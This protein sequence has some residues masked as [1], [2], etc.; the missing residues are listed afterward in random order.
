MML[1]HGAR[2][3]GLVTLGLFAAFAWRA[4]A[5]DERTLQN[6]HGSV[7]YVTGDGVPAHDLAPSAS[8]V[9]ADDDVART[10]AASMASIVLG[11]SSQ[12]LMASNSVLKLDMFSQA[13]IAHAHFVVFAGKMRFRVLHPA[14][15]HADYTFT[16]PT[17]QIGVR[18]TEGDIAVDPFDG[19]RMNVYHLTDPALPVHVT[20]I[21]GSTYD[22]AGGHKIWMRW[23]SGKLVARVTALSKDE[24]DRF[25][26]LGPPTVID[27]G[28]PPK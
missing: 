5:S 22:I 14:G 28:S 25:S 27:G 16:T 7:S 15:A 3:W 19:V 2:R 10:G 12:I 11:D 8:T 9:I 13:E 24:L 23:L 6:L 4:D 20:M 26:E 1:Q 18:G 21:D 17:G